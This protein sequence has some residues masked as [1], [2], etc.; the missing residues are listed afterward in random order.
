MMGF[1]REEG[2]GLELMCILK[3]QEVYVGFSEVFIPSAMSMVASSAGYFSGALQDSSQWIK[4]GL[5]CPLLTSVSLR[6]SLGGLLISLCEGHKTTWCVQPL[7][8]Q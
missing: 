3:R 2:A 8:K 7:T 1:F 4:T 6:A 5:L